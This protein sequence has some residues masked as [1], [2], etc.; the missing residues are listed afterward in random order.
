MDLEAMGLEVEHCLC[1][2]IDGKKDSLRILRKEWI[3]ANKGKYWDVLVEEI[4]QLHSVF[5]VMVLA[6]IRV[7]QAQKEGPT[8]FAFSW[9]FFTSSS[10]STTL[11]SDFVDV[12]GVDAMSDPISLNAARP[13]NTV[14]PRTA[15]NNARGTHEKM[16]L[17]LHIQ[18]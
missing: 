7:I 17:I 6:M 12:N 15:V 10:S 8:N 9:L 16:L 1:L 14:Q 5:C 18:C 2:T 13:V 4:L 3:M 11:R